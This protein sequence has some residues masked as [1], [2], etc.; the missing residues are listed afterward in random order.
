MTGFE[1]HRQKERNIQ[2]T[3][4]QFNK[5]AWEAECYA[6]QI[7]NRLPANLHIVY[8][9]VWL[10]TKNL[11]SKFTKA[12]K[13]NIMLSKYQTDYQPNDTHIVCKF[14]WYPAKPV[15]QILYA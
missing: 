6:Q 2:M 7:S 15:K 13:Q 5:A 14:D 10:V 3:R 12:A 4:G 9:Q 11:L 1:F 8:V